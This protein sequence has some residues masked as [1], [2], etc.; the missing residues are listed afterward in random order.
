MRNNKYNLEPRPNDK[1]NLSNVYITNN[2][3][4]RVIKYA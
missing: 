1:Q 4:K 3:M 2:K